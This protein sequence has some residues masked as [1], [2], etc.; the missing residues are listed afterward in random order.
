VP[1]TTP[2]DLERNAVALPPL[3]V[4]RLEVEAPEYFIIALSSVLEDAAAGDKRRSISCA[5]FNS[6]LSTQP[7]RPPSGRL[8]PLDPAIATR[9]QPTGPISFRGEQGGRHGRRE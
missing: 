2:G 8:E 3:Q 9:P 5:D 4:A 6:P 7:F 1:F